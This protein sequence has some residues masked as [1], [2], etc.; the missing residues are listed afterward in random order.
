MKI[1]VTGATGFIG[2]ILIEKLAKKHKVVCFVRKE[3]NNSAV[4]K[5]EKVY[6]DI[7]DKNSLLE[8]TKKIDAVI[9]LATSHQQGNEDFNFIGSRN[10]IEACKENKVKKLIFISSMAAKRASLDDYGKTKLKIENLIKESGLNYVILRPSIIYSDN[11]LS[12]IGK[13]LKTPLFIPVIG[14]G[15]YKLNPVHI[16]DVAEAI[17]RAVE[18]KNKE[19]D[20]AG[21]EKI[22]FNDIIKL[23]KQQFNI[24]KP[25]IHVPIF[26]C[27]AVFKFFPVISKEALK[28]M[29]EDTNADIS[30][31]KKDL[32]INPISF[33][34]GIKNVNL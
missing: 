22:S 14:N 24:K 16:N 31:L 4:E 15:N 19:Y 12:L 6:G 28:G 18:K 17:T 33:Q 23:C 30:L 1:L 20:V 5:F 3:S 2:R 10:V 8:A 32:K 25:V 34:E 21:A 29:N 26:I 11:N 13:S 7:L 27:L 9:H